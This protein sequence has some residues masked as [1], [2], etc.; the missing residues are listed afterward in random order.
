MSVAFLFD[1]RLL[2]MYIKLITVNNLIVILY[3]HTL[4]DR[5]DAHR[6]SW[7]YVQTEN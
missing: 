7:D 2:V 6:H 5:A 4:P 3:K 1:L